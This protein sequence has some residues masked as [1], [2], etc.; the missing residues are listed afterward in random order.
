MQRSGLTAALSYIV[1]INIGNAA[2]AVK[3][4][5]YGKV[6]SMHGDIFV[7]FKHTQRVTAPAFLTNYE[8]VTSSLSSNSLSILGKG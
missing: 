1:G 8:S 3:F 2:L 5:V 4:T 6:F 7:G